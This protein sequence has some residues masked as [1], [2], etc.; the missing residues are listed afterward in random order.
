MERQEVS[1]KVRAGLLTGT[2]YALKLAEWGL[3]AADVV[4][5]GS[6]NLADT[7]VKAPAL[8][9]GRVALNGIKAGFSILADKL[10]KKGRSL[11]R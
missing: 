3:T 1:T 9:I 8:G 7:F 5:C 10:I 6:N 11:A 4:L 2:G